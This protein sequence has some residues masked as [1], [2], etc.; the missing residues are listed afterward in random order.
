MIYY[1]DEEAS[2]ENERRSF[3]RLQKAHSHI[4]GNHLPSLK[5]LSELDMAY[6]EWCDAKLIMQKIADEIKSGAR[7]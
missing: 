5:E 6:A 3:S 1:H 7:Q 2:I 4:Y